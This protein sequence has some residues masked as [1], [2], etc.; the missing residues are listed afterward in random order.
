MPCK[1]SAG[2]RPAPPPALERLR[3]IALFSGSI[4]R[5]GRPA[6]GRP[7]SPICNRLYSSSSVYIGTSLSRDRHEGEAFLVLKRKLV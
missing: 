7:P 3:R 4:S 2:D 1:H 6:A 5:P